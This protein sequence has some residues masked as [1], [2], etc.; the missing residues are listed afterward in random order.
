MAMPWQ[1]QRGLIERRRSRRREPRPIAESLPAI[2]VNDLQIPRD[3]ATITLPNIGLR[4]P[5][6]AS[7]R[8]TYHSVEVTHGTGRTQHFKLKPIKTGFGRPRYAFVCS[9]GRPVIQLYFRYASLACRRRSNAVHA[10]Q[11]LNKQTRPILKAHRLEA[12]LA[13][14]TNMLSRTRQRLRARL[15]EKALMPQSNYGTGTARHWK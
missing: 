3:Y 1:L 12:F 4:Y 7:M 14:K 15:G 5:R 11:T 2:S 8:L 9:C 6:L 10:S 13:L